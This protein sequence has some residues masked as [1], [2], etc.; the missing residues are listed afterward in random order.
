VEL[1]LDAGAR[2]PSAHSQVNS[3]DDFSA[4]KTVAH[5]CHNQFLLFYQ[6]TDSRGRRAEGVRGRAAPSFEAV[7]ECRG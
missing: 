6:L 2:L 7:G 3:G 1:L 4:K 5:L